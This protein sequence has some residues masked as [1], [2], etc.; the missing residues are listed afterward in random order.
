M[1]HRKDVASVQEFIPF[2]IKTRL[3]KYHSYYYDV[4][5]NKMVVM[6]PTP[7]PDAILDTLDLR[8]ETVPTRTI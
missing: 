2:S 5:A 6:T 7:D 3:P 8:M 1:Q 4:N